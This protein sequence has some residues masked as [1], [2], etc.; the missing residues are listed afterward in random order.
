MKDLNAE[1]WKALHD[2]TEAA[3]EAIERLD[4]DPFIEAL[5]DAIEQAQEIEQSW[6]EDMTNQNFWSMLRMAPF[7]Y[8]LTRSDAHKPTRAHVTDAAWDLYADQRRIVVP[9]DGTVLVPTGVR[10]AFPPGW[11]G[12]I[13]DRSGNFAKMGLHVGAGVIDSGYRGEVL[14]GVVALDNGVDAITIEKGQRIAQIAFMPCF[15]GEL[16]EGGVEDNTDRGSKGF[17]STG[18]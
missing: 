15:A 10:F 9:G 18:K 11:V 14:V 12:R 2:L 13:W 7:R 16:L 4:G 6:L 8:Q 5:G 17:G 1:I 3:E